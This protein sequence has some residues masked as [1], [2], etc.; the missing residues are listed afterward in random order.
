MMVIIKWLLLNKPSQKFN[1]KLFLIIKL[2]YKMIL[3]SY[4][5]FFP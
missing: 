2:L 4:F 1:I 5:H 3:I